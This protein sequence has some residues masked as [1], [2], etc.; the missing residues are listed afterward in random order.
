MENAQN[1]TK[2]G[3]QREPIAL[4]NWDRI[5]AVINYSGMTANAFARHI[6]LLRGENLYQIKRGNNGISFDVANRIVAKFPQVDKLWLLTGDGQM[7]TDDAPSGPWSHI[8]TPNSEAFRAWAAVQLLP[9]FIENN[10]PDPA[11]A[12]LDQVNKLLERLAKKGGIQ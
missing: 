2:Q 3:A 8:G 6:G 11:A 9:T 7:F 10:A 5:E 12:A 4:T 1:N